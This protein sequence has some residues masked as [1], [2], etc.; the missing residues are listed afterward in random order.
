MNNSLPPK[1]II[2][3]V[4]ILSV[5]FFVRFTFAKE[6]KNAYLVEGVADI[7]QEQASKYRELGLECQQMGNLAEALSFYQK[8]IAINPNFAV[9]YN[10]LGIVYEAMGSF[11]R[12][13]EN[14]LKSSKIDP[15]YSSAYTNLALFYEG[16]RNLEKAAFYWGKRVEVGTPDDPWTQKAANRLRDIRSS[17]SNRPFSDER[18]EDVLGL[19][20]DISENK[21]GFNRN[22]ETLSQM[23]FKKAKQSFDRQ[24]MATAIK[25]ALDAQYL[26]QDNQEIEA[27]IEKAELRA[28][29]R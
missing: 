4:A 13:E 14:Y 26:D 25:E 28:L 19:M 27:F 11:G 21:S 5:L 24:D 15:T 7:K 3:P 2:I 18:E 17:L 22:D 23:H 10:D 6:V 20:K 12:A 9:A 8:A 1:L 29:T 16:Q